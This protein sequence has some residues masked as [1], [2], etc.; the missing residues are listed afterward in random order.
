MYEHDHLVELC[1][2]Q[3][4]FAFERVID[5]ISRMPW[6]E[7]SI[8]EVLKIAKVYYYFSIQ[9]RENLAIACRLRPQD[10]CLKT[11][12]REECDT[13]NLS[14]YPGVTAVGEKVNHDEFMR[15]LLA[16][17]PIQQEYML[18][19]AGTAYLRRVREIDDPIRARSIASYEDGGL[20]TV[21]SA[22]LRAP[23]WQ[24][25]GQQA[26]RF[27]LEEHIRFDTDADGGHGALSRHLPVDDDL[28]PLWTAFRDLLVLAAPVL[29]K[30]PSN[31]RNARGDLQ[32]ADALYL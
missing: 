30:I 23:F 26:F 13:D 3:D 1:D 29:A 27:F 14:P 17:Q 24:G 6:E 11:L 16:F 25:A 4:G 10:E 7:V 15:R 5:Q 2:A 31:A 18:D 8:Q 20:S 22:M 32:L 28:L 19:Q 9:F 12:Y 21:F